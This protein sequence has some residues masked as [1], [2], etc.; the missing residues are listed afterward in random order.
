M[1]LMLMLLMLSR[2]SCTFLWCSVAM[3]WAVVGWVEFGVLLAFLFFFS[4]LFI[5]WLAGWL[6]AIV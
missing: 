4:F 1:L 2:L 6:V 3:V 5:L